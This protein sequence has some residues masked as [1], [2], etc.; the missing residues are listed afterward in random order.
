MLRLNKDGGLTV[1]SEDKFVTILSIDT[2]DGTLDMCSF[3]DTSEGLKPVTIVTKFDLE[4]GQH[5]FNTIR[6]GSKTF[7]NRDIQEVYADALSNAKDMRV[8]KN[9]EK[10]IVPIDIGDLSEEFSD[11]VMEAIEIARK[12]EDAEVLLEIDGEIYHLDGSMYEAE[13]EQDNP[14]RDIIDEKEDNEDSEEN[15]DNIDIDDYDDS[16]DYAGGDF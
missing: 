12:K 9:Q 15:P 8:Y 11:I 10:E 16:E 14:D 1:K 5:F 7:D 6:F 4:N 3:K 13:L 2:K